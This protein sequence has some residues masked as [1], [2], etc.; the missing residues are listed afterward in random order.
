[1]K[2]VQ[3]EKNQ[4][5]PVWKWYAIH[6]TIKDPSRKLWE[7]LNIFIN[8]EGYKIHTSYSVSFLYCNNEPTE[9]F[10]KKSHLK[11]LQNIIKCTR[12]HRIKVENSSEWKLPGTEERI[13]EAQS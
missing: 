8:V 13:E 4:I 9:E 7:L 6:E 3:T 12:I 5:I 11:Y 1:M 2:D 10:R